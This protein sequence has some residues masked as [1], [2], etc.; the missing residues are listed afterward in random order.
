[1]RTDDLKRCLLSIER[2]TVLPSQVCVI[3]R[4]TDDQTLRF[5]ETLSTSLNLVTEKIDVPGQVAA[6][7]LG[8]T[9]Y[10][11][12][13]Y[14]F[15]SILDDDVE[16]PENWIDTILKTLRGNKEISGL[17]GRDNVPSMPATSPKKT[18][19]K[20]TFYG[21]LIGNHHQGCGGLREVDTLKGCN[22]TFRRVA[23]QGLRFCTH[24]RGKGA[25]VGNDTEFSLA[26][27]SR[28]FRI[29]YDS[30]IQLVHYA[31]PRPVS[32]ERDP[33]KNRQIVKDSAFNYTHINLKYLPWPSQITFIFWWIFI[34]TRNIPGLVQVINL[35]FFHLVPNTM[36]VLSLALRN[37]MAAYYEFIHRGARRFFPS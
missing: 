11:S 18:V 15:L 29:F 17:G 37:R 31:S 12:S 5:L 4:T 26:V 33:F 9:R 14:E 34:G 16:L 13:T 10:E 36:E 23:V 8:L 7:N 3:V 32:D 30:N 19:G 2:Q 27:K 20:I 25:Q 21:K 24:L 1:M 6:L 22:M 35:K 28:G